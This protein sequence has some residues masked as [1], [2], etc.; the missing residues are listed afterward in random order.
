MKEFNL[1]I[2]FNERLRTT[3]RLG[4]K[5]KLR[6]IKVFLKNKFN[7]KEKFYLKYKQR[8]LHNKDIF[9]SKFYRNNSE[10][11]IIPIK[12]RNRACL[13]QANQK[14]LKTVATFFRYFLKIDVQYFDN[15]LNTIK[16]S[17]PLLFRFILAK[18]N[19]FIKLIF[20]KRNEL[21]IDE[22]T[23]DVNIKD[24]FKSFES[25]FFD[26][27]KSFNLKN[28]MEKKISSENSRNNSSCYYNENNSK[29]SN[30]SK[31]SNHSN[32]NVSSNSNFENCLVQKCLDFN[33]VNG[34]YEFFECNLDKKVNNF[35]AI[36]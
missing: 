11:Q 13:L 18:K 33:V 27:N 36:D 12:N 32:N 19:S 23:D 3:I 24:F 29:S 17:N 10:I 21:K 35:V 6:R 15:I 4:E 16:Y 20:S 14:I 22:F 30:V 28:Y 26:K 2:N 1:R 34:E 8:I 25:I 9:C 7:L 31:N 5:L